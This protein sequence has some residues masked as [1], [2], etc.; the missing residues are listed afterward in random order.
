MFVDH[1]TGSKVY[2]KRKSNHPV[3]AA[4]QYGKSAS[5]LGL[6]DAVGAST[7]FSY[8]LLICDHS[9]YCGFMVSGFTNNCYKICNSW[10][11]DT[12]SRYF[13]TASTDRGYKGV[14]FNLNGHRSVNPRLMSVGLR[15]RDL[16]SV[17]SK[18]MG[19]IIMVP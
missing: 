14:A 13:R 18:L 15:L 6:W 7:T 8:Q 17:F 2:F 12:N 10:C 3:I 19:S 11:G 5:A 4:A 1:Q 16:Y 9:F